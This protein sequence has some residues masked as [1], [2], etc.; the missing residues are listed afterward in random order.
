MIER[1]DGDVRL[2]LLAYNRGERA[3]DRDLRNGRDPENGYSTKVLGSVRDRY[4]G[5]GLLR[6]LR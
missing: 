6:P 4:D 1:Y 5:D 3:V 2:G